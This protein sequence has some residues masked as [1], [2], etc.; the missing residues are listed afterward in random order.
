MKRPPRIFTFAD[1]RIVMRPY[2]GGHDK[3]WPYT[4]LSPVGA[5]LV[6]PAIRAPNHNL[7]EGRKRIHIGASS[8]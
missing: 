7:M 8:F 4:Q 3:S 6:V 5:R 1:G 2:N